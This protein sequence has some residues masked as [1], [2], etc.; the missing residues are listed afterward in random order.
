MERLILIDENGNKTVYNLA[1][2]HSRQLGGYLIG[3]SDNVDP[4]NATEE[5]FG[6]SDL[7]YSNRHAWEKAIELR[8]AG[9][10]K[11]TADAK[12]YFAKHPEEKEKIYGN[13]ERKNT[14]TVRYLEYCDRMIKKS[15][16]EREQRG[17]ATLLERAYLHEEE[18]IKQNNM[19]YTWE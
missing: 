7:F 5:G 12:K 6:N 2:M 18:Y 16:A 9:Y 3:S 1:A 15:I 17:E 10:A 13:D 4:Y 19:F 14:N 8:D 11:I